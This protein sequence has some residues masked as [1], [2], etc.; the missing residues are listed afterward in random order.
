MGS[1]AVW[2]LLKKG[3]V[4]CKISQKISRLRDRSKKVEKYRKNLRNIWN[5][6]KRSNIHVIRVPKTI[7]KEIM[8]EKFTELIK[9][10]KP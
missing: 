4:N 3:L 5:M 10:T 7:F 8:S 9:N 1:T 6:V 2:I